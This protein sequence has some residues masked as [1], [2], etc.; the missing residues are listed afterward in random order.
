[1]PENPVVDVTI[2]VNEMGEIS[3][4]SPDHFVVHKLQDQ[5]V[6]WSCIPDQ[7]FSIEF[8]ND[9]PFYESQF[10][11]DCPCSGIARRNVVADKGRNYKYTVRVG[12]KTLDPDGGVEK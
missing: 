12:G 8:A 7:D 1:M 2:R 5:V 6:R 10:S 9:S 11:R 3:S 4:V